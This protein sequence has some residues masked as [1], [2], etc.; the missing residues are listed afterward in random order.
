MLKNK[1]GALT[2]EIT[3]I[4]S[5]LLL[6]IF[7]LIYL[8]LILY[9]QV[10]LQS[11]ADKVANRAANSWSMPGKDL[12]FGFVAKE[13]M[14]EHSLYWRFYDAEQ[15]QK[16]EKIR[17]FAK[18]DF[19][20]YSLLKRSLHYEITA[21]IETEAVLYKTITVVIESK[22]DNPVKNLLKNV[23]LGSPFHFK[24]T[25][26]AIVNEPAEFVRNTDF[27]VDTLRQYT[28]GM[29]DFKTYINKTV[30]NIFTK[31]QDFIKK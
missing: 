26:E 17:A 22:Y 19:D 10:Y 5:V 7:A 28:P 14:D 30:T 4:F 25:G 18:D 23:G 1:K 9:Q 21:S 12:Y 24:V 11:F 27:A 8:C 6:C 16:L 2:L 13:D 31:L 29:D 3:L 20:K 15:A